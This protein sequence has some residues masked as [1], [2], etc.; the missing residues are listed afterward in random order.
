MKIDGLSSYD[1]SIQSKDVTVRPLDQSKQLEQ[2]QDRTSQPNVEEQKELSKEEATHIISGINEFL[3]PKMT[4]LKFELHEELDRY[5]V[6]VIDQDSD[7]V[8]RE[9]PPRELLDMYA[10]MTE[11]LGLFI[12]EK[13]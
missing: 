2:E 1:S 13:L 10:K 9:I 5:I 4:S 8:I 3:Q 6:Q 12:D 7:E 11:F